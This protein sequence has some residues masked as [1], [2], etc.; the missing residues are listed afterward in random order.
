MANK[1]VR[2]PRYV[3]L[4]DFQPTNTSQRPTGRRPRRLA[5]STAPS[6]PSSGT[7]SA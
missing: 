7:P 1:L 6:T 2:H 3:P 4:N 5:S